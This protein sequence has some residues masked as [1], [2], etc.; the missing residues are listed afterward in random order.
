MKKAQK[1]NDKFAYPHPIIKSFTSIPQESLSL[2]AP[3]FLPCHTED[4]NTIPHK[5]IKSTHI[6]PLLGSSFSLLLHPLHPKVDIPVYKS[7]QILSCKNCK[8]KLNSTCL[9]KLSLFQ[10]KCK[11]CG[12]VNET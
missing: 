1:C 7:S 4:Q 9:Y 3:A 12:T 10:H 11:F 2:P 5:F 8:A 6:E